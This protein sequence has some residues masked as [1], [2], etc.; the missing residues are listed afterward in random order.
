MIEEKIG[1]ASQTLLN[2]PVDTEKVTD[3]QTRLKKRKAARVAKIR[4]DICLLCGAPKDAT[5][6]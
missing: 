6:Q 5:D 2:I 3:N 1:P 4:G